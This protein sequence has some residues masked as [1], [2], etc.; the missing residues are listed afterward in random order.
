MRR[1]DKKKLLI[2]HNKEEFELWDQFI[3][4]NRIKY[5]FLFLIG[6]F[7]GLCLSLTILLLVL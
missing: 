7:L 4:Y 2:M 1:K 3:L 5:S 6:F